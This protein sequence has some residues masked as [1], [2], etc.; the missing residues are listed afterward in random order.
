M[1]GLPRDA[2]SVEIVA[3]KTGCTYSL[4]YGDANSSTLTPIVRTPLSPGVITHQIVNPV[5]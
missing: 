4:A 2:T 1:T 3:Q 5:R